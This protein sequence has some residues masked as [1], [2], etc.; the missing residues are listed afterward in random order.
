MRKILSLFLSAVLLTSLAGCGQG[1]GATD[2][3]ESPAG[4]ATAASGISL[5][6]GEYERGI[7]YGFLP[8][9][10]AAA[11]PEQTV[12]TW[13]QYCAILGRM[14]ARYDDNRLPEWEAM[15]ADAPDTEMKRDGAAV[16][17]YFAGKTMDLLYF[18]SGFD[19]NEE[20]ESYDWGALASWDYPVF[21]WQQ[22]AYIDDFWQDGDNC[23]GV[24]VGYIIYRHSCITG[25]PLLDADSSGWR[26]DGDL[27]LQDAVISAVRLYESV[28]EIA[29]QTAEELLAAVMETEQAQALAAEADAR[30]QEIRNSQTAIV[31]S[32]EY[33]QGETYTG[34][35]YYVSNDGDD[36]NDGLSPETPFATLE[37]LGQV[38]FS[39]GDP[40][41]FERGS[42][43][44]RAQL[45]A[46]IVMT[47][48]ITLSA[49]GEGEKPKF[50]GSPENGTGAENWELYYEGENGERIWRYKSEM[51]DCPAMVGPDDTLIAKRDMAYWDES[52]FKVYED[53]SQEYDLTEQLKN[54]ELFVDLPY[55]GSQ[56]SNHIFIRNYDEASGQYTYLTGPLYVRLD[57]GNPGELYESIEFLA[58][59]AFSDGLAEYT[60]IDNLEIAY[61]SRT[62]CLG[63]SVDGDSKDHITCQ[64]SVAAWCGGQ[65]HAFGE[66][67]MTSQY[68]Y[69]LIDG[70]GFNTNGSYET[71]RDCYAHHCFQ[72]GIALETF[73]DDTETCENVTIAGNLVEYCVM[74][75]LVVSWDEEPRA[76][77]L[78][79]NISVQNNYVLYSGF[80]NY[81]NFPVRL[82]PTED[83]AQWDWGAAIGALATDANAA[84]GFGPDAHDGTYT[85]SGNT[86]AFAFGNIFHVDSYY[87]EYLNY[88]SGNTY[89]Q[90]PGFS[91]FEI[92]NYSESGDGGVRR[93]FLD[94]EEAMDWLQDENA[95]IISFN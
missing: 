26:A 13:E 72:E 27:T 21:D 34:T 62:V 38:Q 47:E 85:S 10:L 69:A 3:Q 17:L 36:D 88:L 75:S 50:Y 59:Y 46:S 78:F 92:Y 53:I 44:R 8:E 41:F 28:E 56:D 54:G 14:I 5:P 49:Y 43:W 77:H 80:E 2:V 42:L 15:T 66:S 73:A 48:G 51:T 40:V 60:T 63:G 94:A 82:P 86:F 1:D 4:Q 24:A 7:W 22:P 18:N 9:E 20:F 23:V 65:I 58:S 79:E 61:S 19:W 30:R 83:G 33:V 32:G 67:P 71:I 89:A 84:C 45:P 12:V 35:A 25:L 55:G 37:R 64:N 11:D 31:K 91:W 95:N 74:G 52:G 87:E 70:G 57:E 16:A 76:E 81:Y 29:F 39:F 6:A 93:R 90:I 68:G